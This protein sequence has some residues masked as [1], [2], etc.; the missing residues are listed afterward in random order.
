MTLVAVL[1]ALALFTLALAAW[2]QGRGVAS[3]RRQ[4]GVAV[5]LAV[6]VTVPAL[7]VAVV[8][9]TLFRNV[10]TVRRVDDEGRVRRVERF[11]PLGQPDVI[12]ILLVWFG[13]LNL[14]AQT[15]RLPRNLRHLQRLPPLADVASTA[16]VR[17]FAGR[18][19]VAPPLVVELA[20][21]DGTMDVQAFTGGMLA[22][23]V[24]LS[25][26][27][28][29]GLPPDERDAILAHELAHIAHRD[30]LRGLGAAVLA[31][32]AAVALSGW[33]PFYVAVPWMLAATQFLGV[34]QGHRAEL[35]ADAA[36]GRCAGYAAA[37]RALDKIHATNLEA[38]SNPW[39]HA[40]GSHPAIVVRAEHL[41]RTAPPEARAQIEVDPARAA[42]CRRARRAA[43]AIWAGLLVVVAALGV[44]Q[45]FA[46]AATLGALLLLVPLLPHLRLVR[47][48]REEFELGPGWRPL[49]AWIGVRAAL[50]VAACGAFA[51]AQFVRGWM[52]VWLPL[53][54]GAGLIVL[55]IGWGSR[56]RRAHRDLDVF[57]LQGDLAG[58]QERAA[59][60]PARWRRRPGFRLFAAL[61]RAA[62]G[63]RQ[64]AV[65][66][67]LELHREHPRLRASLLW[68]AFLL[69]DDDPAAAEELA[70]E[71][72]TAIPGNATAE[73][74]LVGALR[75]AGRLDEAW[76]RVESLL[77]RPRPHG[78]WYAVA[79]RLALARGE[80]ERAAALLARAEREASGDTLTVLTRAAFDAATGSADAPASLARLRDLDRRLPLAFLRREIA[81]LER[82]DAA[83]A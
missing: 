52:P 6:I 27:I 28:V 19:G 41:A 20:T 39:V 38:E 17:E 25:D 15:L 31:G 7:P 59:R 23:V 76:E 35:R 43:L 33:T 47:E 21:T 32:T 8:G 1:F 4:L 62:L 63:E 66:D 82:A 78:R 60:L 54:G 40:M 36:A 10:A 75:A 83:P 13:L 16:R 46:S 5:G 48:L 45:H 2:R 56:E 26:G 51:S 22:P 71:L 61:A 12:A 37:A 29:H 67:L 58:W 72:T 18:L 74:V 57:L 24:A 70:R 55:A 44:C 73:L 68:A 80:R 30:Q 42:A 50:F 77:R 3:V 14:A 65:A 53:L 9:G 11:A 64:A 34:L 69:R 49:L 81:S 79:G